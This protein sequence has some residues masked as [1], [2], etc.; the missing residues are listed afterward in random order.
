M[1]VTPGGCRLGYTFVAANVCTSVRALRAAWRS[2]VEPDITH[3][4]SYNMFVVELNSAQLGKLM[5]S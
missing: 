5:S 1:P 3:G 4:S 2:T